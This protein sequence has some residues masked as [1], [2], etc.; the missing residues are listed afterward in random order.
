MKK[1]AGEVRIIEEWR[2]RRKEIG[3]KEAEKK[4]KE[5]EKNSEV[6]ER[7]QEISFSKV[8]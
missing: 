1:K 6:R 8:P 7:G 2:R 3:G 5:E 4:E